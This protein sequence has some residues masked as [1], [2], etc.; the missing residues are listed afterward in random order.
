[1]PFPTSPTNGQTATVNNISYVYS[2]A[3]NTWIKAGAT[4][5][6]LAAYAQLGGATFTGN[7]VLT[8]NVSL[9]ANGPVVGSINTI[10][11]STT[12]VINFALGN[13]FTMTF[14]TGNATFSA[15]NITAGQSGTIVLIQDSAGGRTASWTGDFKFAGGTPPTLSTAANAVDVLPYFIRASGN[16]VIG[17]PIQE[18]A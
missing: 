7:L 9:T 8:S 18:V 4:A 2:S 16:V 3:N 1:M 14:G 13:N 5:G 6:T 17:T 10:T 11:Y 15:S 12:P